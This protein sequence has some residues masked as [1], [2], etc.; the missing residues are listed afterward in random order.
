MAGAN[1]IFNE[2]FKSFQA[3]EFFADA[4]YELSWT[5]VIS[6]AIDRETGVRIT[7]ENTYSCSA[8][9]TNPSKSERPMDKVFSQY[10][11]GDVVVIAR[12]EELEKKPPL[13]QTVTFDGL[14]YTCKGIASDPVKV[15]WNLLLRR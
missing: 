8:A 12:Q 4:F 5:E 9:L 2:L 10:Q 13:E 11:I 3:S 7:T 6:G 15:S 14:E 1:E